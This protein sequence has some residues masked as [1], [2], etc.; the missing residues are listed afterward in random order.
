MIESCA[1]AAWDENRRVC[2]GLVELEPWDDETEAL[3]D[4]WR[5]IARAILQA[6]REPTEAMVRATLVQTDISAEQIQYGK[7]VVDGMPPLA[8][9]RQ[10]DGMIAAAELVRDWQAMI[11]Q[12]L[13]ED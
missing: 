2:E 13:A 8:P 10:R 3:R 11:D 6:L 1:R 7:A 5:G 9:E 4:N 12:A